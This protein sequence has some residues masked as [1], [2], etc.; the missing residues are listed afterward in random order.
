[1][2][3]CES[4]FVMVDLRRFRRYR[5]RITSQIAVNG[6][7]FVYLQGHDNKNNSPMAMV[8]LAP[9]EVI[10]FE[11]RPPGEIWAWITRVGPRLE[12]RYFRGPL[13]CMMSWQRVQQ[14]K[15]CAKATVSARLCAIRIWAVLH[16]PLSVYR[17]SV[18]WLRRSPVHATVCLCLSISWHSWSADEPAR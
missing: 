4:T 11:C 16:T 15:M 14:K 12:R 18:P 3:G 13:P 7:R 2:F 8:T 17:E 10:A 5:R 9:N 6:Y 1:M